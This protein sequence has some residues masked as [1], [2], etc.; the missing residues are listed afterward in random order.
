MIKLDVK[1]MSINVAWQ[2][3]RFKTPEYRL[4]TK[5]INKA[6]LGTR[7]IKESKEPF[8]VHYK[9]YLKN[10]KMTDVGNLEKPLTDILVKA[11]IIN[12][13]R[14][15]KKIILEKFES[16]QNYIEIFIKGV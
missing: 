16:E 9:F 4:F 6:L 1:G 2:G 14:Y 5:A 15:I 7:Q 8:Q 3:K 13:D 12:D 10:Y 11:K